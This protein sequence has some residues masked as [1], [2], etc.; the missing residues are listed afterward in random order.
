MLCN[1][2]PSYS[3]YYYKYL[4]IVVE[5]YLDHYKVLSQSLKDYI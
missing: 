1:N 5:R 2:C 3:F 4:V